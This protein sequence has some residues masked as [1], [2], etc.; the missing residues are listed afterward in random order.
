M[1]N[2]KGLTLFLSL[3]VDNLR[4][5]GKIGGEQQPSWIT[6]IQGNIATLDNLNTI[7]EYQIELIQILKGYWKILIFLL[8]SKLEISRR[9]INNKSIDDLLKNVPSYSVGIAWMV[10]CQQSWAGDISYYTFRVTFYSCYWSYLFT[11]SKWTTILC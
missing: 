8:C 1:A 5:T 9:I 10:I 7:V 11:F 4:E 6:C 3:E 2:G